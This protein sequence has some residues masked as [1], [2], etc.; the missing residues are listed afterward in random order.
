MWENKIIYGA[1]LRFLFFIVPLQL[2][3][4]IQYVA[5]QTQQIDARTTFSDAEYYFLYQDF[6][7]ALP[8]YLKLA[9]EE[10][11]NSN[12][13]Y[14]IGVCYLNLSGQ[15]VKAIPYL[16]RAS[17]SIGQN[18]REGSFKETSA[19]IEALFHLGNA[20]RIAN[21]IDE[22][23]ESFS[24]YK[25]K[26]D[27]KDVINYDFAVQQV[28]ACKRAREMMAMPLSVSYENLNLFENAGKYSHSPILSAN[29]DHLI[30]SVQ[31]KFY[32]AIY[33]AK[34]KGSSWGDPIN[35]T[36][37]LGAEGEI[38]A[39]SI[40]ANG[41]QIFLFKNDRGVGNIYTSVFK[42]DKW[43]KIIKVGGNINSRY[44]ETNASITSDG[45]TLF[46][47]SN[48]RG[49][50]GGLDIYYSI[51]LPSG[52]W[53]TPINLG[54]TINTP[55]NEESPYLMNDNET[56]VFSSQGHNS[57]GGYDIFSSKR[58]DENIWSSPSNMGYP[59]STTDDDMSF[60]PISEGKGLVSIPDVL[61][62]NQ[63]Q[64]SM[65]TFSGQV[66]RT[67]IPIKGKLLLSDNKEVAG[68]VFNINISDFETGTIIERLNPTGTLGEFESVVPPG[69]Y[70]IVASGKGYFPDT[71]IVAIPANFQQNK[72]PVSFNLVP[73]SVTKGEFLSV[74]SIQFDFDSYSLS[75]DSKFEAERIYGFMAKY[76]DVTIQVTGHTD[77]KGSAAYNKMLSQKRAQSLIDYLTARGVA[78]DRMVLKAAGPFE[79]IASNINPDGTDNPEGRL[80]NR[81][82]TI[83]L[84][85]SSSNVQLRDE[86]EVPEHL[87]PR[88]QQYAVLLVPL[89]QT[90]SSSMLGKLK[91]SYK[92]E[93]KVIVGTGKHKAY[94]VGSFDH[95]AEAISLLDKCIDMGFQN[96]SLTGIDDLTLTVSYNSDRKSPR[97]EMAKEKLLTI[98]ILSSFEAA[99]VKIPNKIVETIKAKD[100]ML[101]YIYGRYGN[102]ESA[103][104]DLLQIKAIYPDAFVINIKRYE[105]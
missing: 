84:E 57:M 18:Y 21:R 99:D 47:T 31:E 97:S 45:K 3:L 10:P 61:S 69:V 80:Y 75:R 4:Q 26:L 8:L 92:L 96:A 44:W 79:N 9:E 78:K 63:R 22:A 27:P 76:P 16:E 94:I 72:Y 62:P 14:K 23:I 37:D 81:R 98:Q 28:E 34:R 32:D 93:P 38:Y 83:A 68:S 100:G 42:D 12:I 56:L 15:K 102:V 1:T 11:N 89:G 29:G 85:N 87:K 91:Q 55:F 25:D 88:I 36:L 58:I 40:N 30:F 46:F 65:V 71:L 39:T 48:R 86:L 7:E 101:K 74:R 90:P 5:A 33:W 59:I 77:S 82:A 2:L 54:P 53:G 95:K 43:S 73:E 67:H 41:T 50:F 103:D 104:S 60:F 70:R 35:I 49:G 20:Y 66:V 6:N 64:I 13:C 52:Q 105:E 24:Q 51:L 19:P 17:K